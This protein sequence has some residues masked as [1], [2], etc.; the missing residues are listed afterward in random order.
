M[1]LEY[2]RQSVDHNDI[3]FVY[4]WDIDVVPSGRNDFWV[5]GN[6]FEVDFKFSISENRV[7]CFDVVDHA[8]S[9]SYAII[10]V[11]RTDR[12]DI[13]IEFIGLDGQKTLSL[14]LIAKMVQVAVLRMVHAL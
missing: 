10:T 8:I 2:Y 11:D 9:A 14:T 4:Y 3:R 12:G 6:I 1:F 13:G 5:A 7:C